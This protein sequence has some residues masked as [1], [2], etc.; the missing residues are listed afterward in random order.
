M[1][2]RT[3]ERHEPIVPAA[4]EVRALHDAACALA[5]SANESATLTLP[6][7]STVEIPA[8]LMAA[9]RQTLDVMSNNLAVEITPVDRRLS[10]YQA[11]RMLNVR[12]EYVEKL[13]ENGNIPVVT[14]GK[15]R[16]IE[17]EALLAYKRVKDAQTSAA[18]DELTRLSEEMGLYDIEP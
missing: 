6:N 17:F 12:E 16:Y 9:I 11:A 18:L 15:F 8:P 5:G 14:K 10:P 1:A 13:L 4:D 3:V 7:G 2:A